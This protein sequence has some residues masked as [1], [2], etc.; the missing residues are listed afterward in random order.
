MVTTAALLDALYA[1]FEAEEGSVFR[2]MHQGTPYLTRA[3][4]ETQ[5]EIEAMAQTSVRHAAEIAAL[6]EQFGG[7]IGLAPVH[8]GNQY[9]AYLS[10]KFLIPKLA[11]AKRRMLE[12][13]ENA[14]RALK[15][16]PPEVVELLKRHIDEHRRE[17]TSLE[18]NEPREVH[19][20]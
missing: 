18:A 16:A 15:D 1:L 12:R 19:H 11:D 2:F 13:Y 14:L 10:L 5:R 20:A 7:S 17:L 3:T 4:V 8:P 6:I 9:L